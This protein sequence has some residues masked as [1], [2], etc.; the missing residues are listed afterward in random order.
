MDED[1][2]PIIVTLLGDETRE[3]ID[4]QDVSLV[5]LLVRSFTSK[6][7]DAFRLALRDDVTLDEAVAKIDRL[8]TA[9]NDVFLG[10]D[11]A[12][13]VQ[14]GPWNT[15]EQLGQFLQDGLGLEE[16]AEQSVRAVLI[17]LAT[18]VMTALQRREGDWPSRLDMLVAEVRDLLCGK[19]PAAAGG[20]DI[21]FP[22]GNA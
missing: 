2:Q 22:P 20:D 13:T 18:A 6:C 15:P 19:P 14:C 3:I 16:P 11:P 5:E 12:G 7:L 9:M 17:R 4:L 10:M 1:R 21:V 8:A